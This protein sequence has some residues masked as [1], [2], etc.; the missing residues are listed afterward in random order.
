MDRSSRR[1]GKRD[2][3]RVVAVVGPII[4]STWSGH[5]A[6]PLERGVATFA[7]RPPP[8]A[9]VN[10]VN[11]DGCGFPSVG[12]DCRA[13]DLISMDGSLPKDRS[14]IYLSNIDTTP[15]APLGL[16]VMIPR[17]LLSIF[18]VNCL[19]LLLIQEKQIIMNEDSII[20]LTSCN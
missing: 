14:T 20:N 7:H 12:L 11:I 19:S 3:P 8:P 13:S 5:A 17:I 9:N 4:E 2:S 1:W 10:G 15:K 16:R 6:S 18:A